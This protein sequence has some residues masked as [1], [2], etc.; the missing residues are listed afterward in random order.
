MVF[1][2]EAV[3]TYLRR[4]LPALGSIRHVRK[5]DVGQSNPTYLLTTDGG[6]C[7]LRAKPPGKLLKSAHAIERE[8][9]IL[10]ALYGSDVPGPRPLHL[11]ADES[12]LGTAFYVMEYVAGG[13]HVD[14]TLP[15]LD[16]RVR[17]T[18]YDSSC[19]LLARLNDV[20]LATAGI[21]DYGRSEG[22]WERLVTRWTEQYR[23]AETECRPAMEELISGL[24]SAVPPVKYSPSL[25]HGDFR[26]D[27]FIVD[28][29]G[30]IQAVLDWELST[31]GAPY[32]DL[33]YQ[34]AQWRLP[35]GE[36]RGLG[37][38]DR[39]ALGIPTE[40]EY[41]DSYCR[42]RHLAGLPH[43]DFYLAASLFR[44]AAI[45]QGIYRRGLEGN[46]SNAAAPGFGRKTEVIAAVAVQII[47]DGK[48][49]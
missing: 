25:V 16:P 13:V 35:A 14:P 11:C 7:V 39:R 48:Q 20:D 40:Q 21:E 2:A 36:M 37:G 3:G 10:E 9:R 30:E 34:C 8:F 26:F 5:F 33:A 24:P 23:A 38:L 49:T 27:N 45:C 17:R 4:H 43:W 46:A 32:A 18:L 19:R 42:R 6:R 41:V 47:S 29:D 28:E 22:Y 44:L 12:V 15:G 31:L 1:P